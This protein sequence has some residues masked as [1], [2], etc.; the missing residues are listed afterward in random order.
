M[1]DGVIIQMLVRWAVPCFVMIS[2]FLLLDGQKEMSLH[3]IR[4][5]ILRMVAVLLTFGYCYC[6]IES[7]ATTGFADIPAQLFS[8][9]RNL[10]EGKSW[11][12]MWYVYMV[13]GIYLLTPMI[14]V[15]VNH[16]DHQ[17]VLWI[18]VVL[19]M[20]TIVRPTINKLC[21]LCIDALIP[22]SSCFLWYYLLG[23]YLTRNSLPGNV[24][25]GLLIVGGFGVAFMQMMVKDG[26]VD[27][28]SPDNMFTAMYAVGL[29]SLAK[30]NS[31]LERMGQNK[32]IS[33]VSKYSFG[34]YLIHP[35]FLNLL[36]KGLHITPDIYPIALGEA[37]FFLLAFTGA[38]TLTWLLI[39]IRPL[40][41]ILQ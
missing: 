25:A 31:A 3:K 26:T 30:G 6:L 7:F 39:R 4:K 18:L 13:I 27:A 24:S 21:G 2:G 33:T 17:T 32:L 36:I 9:V 10:L 35:F 1:F 15:F 28:A 40:R 8:S 38:Y 20:L 23:G 14:R 19:F 5:Y 37:F 22:I 34:I 16:A 12:H 11:A 41:N 29:F